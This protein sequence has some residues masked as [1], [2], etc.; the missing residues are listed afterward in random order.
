MWT[1]NFFNVPVPGT[2]FDHGDRLEAQECGHFFL[3]VCN[4]TGLVK[5][6]QDG[7]ICC[8]RQ[9]FHTAGNCFSKCSQGGK[10]EQAT[11]W[12]QHSKRSRARRLYLSWC[13]ITGVPFRLLMFA[14]PSPSTALLCLPGRE[15][16]YFRVFSTK[17]CFI[18][19][20]EMLV[21]TLVF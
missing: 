12:P 16:L 17:L 13:H 19:C 11:N 21:F 9:E 6:W 15:G 20:I 7:Q 5:A 18:W 3:C 8:S 1:S 10:S 4:L 2:I 14:L